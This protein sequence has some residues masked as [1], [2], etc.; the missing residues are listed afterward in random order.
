MASVI[1]SLAEFTEWQDTDYDFSKVKTVYLS[2]MDTSEA[3]V[4]ESVRDQKYKD[5]YRKK[6]GKIKV[7]KVVMAPRNSLG[8]C[9][10]VK[11]FPVKKQ[12]L[13]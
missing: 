4:A 3:G 1:P 7:V 13:L 12:L 11:R 2:G 5:D 6:A 9:C 8:P 10:L